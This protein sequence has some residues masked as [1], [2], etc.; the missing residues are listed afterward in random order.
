MKEVEHLTVEKARSLDTTASMEIAKA[1][2]L[3]LLEK[4]ARDVVVLDLRDLVDYAEYFVICTGRNPRQVKAISDHVR[5][6][7]KQSHDCVIHGVEGLESGQWVL[8]DLGDIIVHV[9]DERSRHFYDLGG[10]WSDARALDIPEIT[11]SE[12]QS[13]NWSF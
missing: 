12:E 13:G 10:L 6:V 3:A 1:L 2:A 7:A 11:Q 4:K 8:I 9:F 5:Q